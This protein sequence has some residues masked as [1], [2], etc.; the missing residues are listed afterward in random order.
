MVESAPITIDG[1]SRIMGLIGDPIGQVRTPE[2]INPIFTT[3]QAGIICIPIHIKADNLAL[4]IAGLKTMSNFVGFGV[5]IPHK[6]AI[7]PLC[8][9]LDP[10]AAHIGA[11]TLVR[12]EKDGSFRGYQLDGYGFVAGLRKAGITLQGRCCQIVGAGGAARAIAF[13]LAQADVAA[14]AIANRHHDKA[15]QL[16]HSLNQHQGQ[17]I[18]YA[19]HLPHVKDA[20]L[21]N[22]T[23][24]GLNPSDPLP[25]S[26]EGVD[27]GTVAA[28]VVACP[29]E[30][31]F[32]L[33]ARQ[34]GAF[35]HSGIHMIEAQAPIIAD[36]LSSKT[37][38]TPYP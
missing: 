28:E 33:A 24:L 3:R 35:T 36:I 27:T 29:E 6:Q 37:A 20:L 5:T 2:I 26:L 19:G 4:S 23:S 14:I 30:T 25:L 8:D 9:S 12:R 22:A 18:A 16:A 31:P 11:V 34:A 38:A 17:Q 10:I 21:I 7:L 15:V 13:A 32:L 1:C